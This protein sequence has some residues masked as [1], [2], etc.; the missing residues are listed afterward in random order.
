MTA[1]SRPDTPS[2]AVDSIT[3]RAFPTWRAWLLALLL[4][5]VCAVV[6]GYPFWSTIHFHDDQ[7]HL[8]EI[9]RVSG[10]QLGL[11]TYLWQP[12]NEHFVPLWKLWY[13]LTWRLCGI[14]S[15][16]WHLSITAAHILG[17]LALF[18]LMWRYLGAAAAWT[19]LVLWAGGTGR[20]ID[21]ALIW[22]AASHLTFGFAAAQGAMLAVTWLD[23][24][25]ARTAYALMAGCI[26]IAG[27]FMGAMLFVVAWLPLQYA[28]VQADRPALWR[29]RRAWLLAW[30]VPCLLILGFQVASVLLPSM[31]D[32]A[33]Q[34]RDTAPVKSLVGTFCAFGTALV[35][36]TYWPIHRPLTVALEAKVA[37]AVIALVA[38]LA[39]A[40]PRG[41]KLIVYALLVAGSYTFIAYAG[42]AHVSNQDLIQWGRYLYLPEW[43]WCVILP[44]AFAGLLT[45]FSGRLRA[46]LSG[47][48]TTALLVYLARQHYVA[49]EIAQVAEIILQPQSSILSGCETLLDAAAQHSAATH[50]PLRLPDV[51]LDFPVYDQTLSQV[52]AYTYPQ[53]LPA[54]VQ[55]VPPEQLDSGNWLE[56]QAFL[57]RS[58]PEDAQNIVA[59]LQ[60][61]APQ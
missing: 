52:T 8:V 42:R 27:A 7:L 33:A 22:I 17:S 14:Q 29:Q 23:G 49:R 9:T 28:L 58:W 43:A 53:G 31:D 47:V 24:P 59:A 26:L 2:A 20:Q 61:Q 21:N 34:G 11:A 10:G 30:L 18:G 4:A 57:R 36:R 6:T 3:Q 51:L 16:G 48:V 13:F 41:R 25:R 12:H 15:L 5:T 60:R 54:S 40:P 35:S 32:L 44:A 56:L 38:C 45:R 19:A 1:S 50:Q 55:F 46:A 39:I 37:A